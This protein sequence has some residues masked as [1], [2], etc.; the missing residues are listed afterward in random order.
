MESM[1]IS[2]FIELDIDVFVKELKLGTYSD[3]CFSSST[4][5]ELY[6]PS[7]YILYTSIVSTLFTASYGGKITFFQRHQY[8]QCF[9]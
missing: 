2:M 1:I 7:K 3:V 9:T 5:V 4:P 8:I 6:A